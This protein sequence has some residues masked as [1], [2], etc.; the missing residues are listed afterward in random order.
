MMNSSLQLGWALTEHEKRPSP[1]I[2][3]SIFLS[4]KIALLRRFWDYLIDPAPLN[5]SFGAKDKTFNDAT[6]LILDGTAKLKSGEL[7]HLP[8]FT[9]MVSSSSIF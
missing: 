2:R 1:A 5:M 6:D 7:V 3:T 4:P 8:H 9:L